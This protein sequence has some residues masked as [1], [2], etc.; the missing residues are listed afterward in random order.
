MF[1]DYDADAAIDWIILTFQNYLP[2]VQPIFDFF[3][4]TGSTI[5]SPV[6]SI[7]S[8][9]ATIFR[10]IVGLLACVFKPVW[11]FVLMP[12]GWFFLIPISSSIF[13][14]ASAM[15]KT[16]ILGLMV[17]ICAGFTALA[18]MIVVVGA[19][20]LAL[21]V[22]RAV[23]E[24][25]NEACKAAFSFALIDTKWLDDAFFPG[26]SRSHERVKSLTEVSREEK[27][28]LVLEDGEETGEEAQGDSGAELPKN[29]DH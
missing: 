25:I 2:P 29:D 5:S 1:P 11:S 18:W 12:I 10:P 20:Y 27:D 6:K 13:A 19:L 3:T 17:Y 21:F 22:I 7:G 9:I 23:I 8:S 15:V 28:L 16:M 14:V 26:R 4:S 24:V